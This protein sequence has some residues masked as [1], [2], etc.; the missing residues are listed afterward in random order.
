VSAAAQLAPAVDFAD[1]D[2]KLLI[3]NDLYKGMQVVD[4]KITLSN[5]PGIGL[6]LL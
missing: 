1:L 2:G 5:L 4:G 3:T 6:E